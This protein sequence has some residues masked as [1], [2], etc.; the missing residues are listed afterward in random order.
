[1]AAMKLIKLLTG[2][3]VFIFVIGLGACVYNPNYAR[4]PAR[5][6]APYFYDYYYYPNV[7][8][9]FDLSLGYYYYRSSK[10]W[11]RT[12]ALPKHIYLDHRYRKSLHMEHKTPY[13]KHPEHRQKY[14]HRNEYR[15]EKG[16]VRRDM[17]RK[18]REYNSRQH[19]Q[20]RKRSEID[21]RSRR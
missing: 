7:D 15:H 14:S 9:Y 21:K 19:K 4:P 1:M 20:Y 8:V 3:L 2:S 12:R 18:E 5:I 13:V 11:A 17:N 16:K 10:H 6:H